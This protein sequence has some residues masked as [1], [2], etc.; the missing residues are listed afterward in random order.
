MGTTVEALASDLSPLLVPLGLGL[1]AS[2][3]A[4]LARKA[5]ERAG[6]KPADLD[7]LEINEA[8]AAQ[9]CAVHQEMGWDINK[10]N[11]NGG[12]IALG[13]NER[14]IARLGAGVADGAVVK[15]DDLYTVEWA[16]IPHFYNA[17]YVFQYATSIAASS[18]F[19]EAIL[20]GE[21]GARCKSSE[22]ARTFLI[23][24]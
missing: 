16:Y 14:L 5:L 13:A 3:G 22:R 8:F 20:K 19:A 9:A 2:G 23:R 7:L 17:F 24:T 10:V 6:W 11:V 18:L 12:A 15:I 21:P 4:L 1:A